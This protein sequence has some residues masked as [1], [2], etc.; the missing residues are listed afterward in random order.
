MTQP[1]R[2]GFTLFA[3]ATALAVLPAGASVP[4]EL[5]PALVSNAPTQPRASIV[6]DIDGDG[7]L[8]IITVDQ[9]GGRVLWF[10]NRLNENLD[11]QAWTVDD[12]IEGPV[13]VAVGDL[14]GDGRLDIAVSAFSLAPG[15]ASV[16]WYRN[17]GNPRTNTPW[18]KQITAT[19]LVFT[20]AVGIAD[21]NNNG[22]NDIIA[23][24]AR[25]SA[26]PFELVWYEN[27][28]FEGNTT[29]LAVNEHIIED[30]IPGV[31]SLAFGDIT[32][33]GRVDVAV[34]AASSIPGNQRRLIAF[35][36]NDGDPT[37]GPWNQVAIDDD[38]Q[39]P[40]R[41]T[42]GDFN[43]NGA[44]DAVAVSQG[45]DRIRPYFNTNGNG[46]LWTQG[47]TLTPDAPVSIRGV[48]LNQNGLLDLVVSTQGAAA[49]DRV[50]WLENDGAGN[51]TEFPVL[52]VATGE[53]L[54]IAT[55]DIR[56]DGDADIVVTSF[57]GG[58]VS[59]VENAA[60]HRNA[61]FNKPAVSV[62]NT[63]G[64]GGDV[65]AA[66]LDRNGL[67]DI[68]TASPNQGSVRWFANTNDGATWTANTITGSLA[69]VT[70]LAVG[71]LAANGRIE[72]VTASPETGRVDVF[73]AQNAAATSWSGVNL[74]MSY[75]RASD[76]AVADVLGNGRLDVIAA[77]PDA[78]L[79]DIVWFENQTGSGVDWAFP[80]V[81]LPNQAGSPA[82]GVERR[83]AVGDITKNGLPDVVSGLT[84]TPGLT[85]RTNNGDGSFS[86]VT[87]DSD[88]AISGAIFA[89]DINGNGA[90]DIV[91]AGAVAGIPELAWFRNENG[92]GSSWQR[93][94][95]TTGDGV[96]NLIAVDSLRL[97]GTV[98][99]L[100]RT[101]APTLYIND[102]A[103]GFS[104][105]IPQPGFDGV[106]R[107]A[108][109]D[110]DRDGDPD[111]AVLR[112][113]TGDATGQH[114]GWFENAG[115]QFSFETEDIAPN[116]LSEGGQAPVLR[117]RP[118][119]EGLVDDAD[120]QITS[121]S[122]R[123]VEPNG[124]PYASADVN[125]MLDSLTVYFDNGN[126]I[127]EPG[128]DTVVETISTFSLTD[129]LMSVDFDDD[130]PIMRLAFGEE[131]DYWIAV[132]AQPDG[133]SALALPRFRI[134]HVT[135]A[136]STAIDGNSDLPLSMAFTP[137]TASSVV[138]VIDPASTPLITLNGPNPLQWE[139]GDSPFVDP[140]AIVDDPNEGA[141]IPISADD[142]G[143]VDVNALGS[144]ILNYSYMGLS[145]AAPD[146]SR[147][148]NVVDTTPP[149]ISL[150]GDAT[151]DVVLGID[152]AVGA[153]YVDPGAT[154]V[155]SFEGDIS[156]AIVV[157]NPVNTAVPGIY[158]VRFNVS[159][160]S[161]NAATEVTRTVRVFDVFAPII[162]L[163]GG[164]SITVEAGVP[165]VDPGFTAIDDVDGD[166]TGQVDVTGTVNT[167]V[168]GFYD[169]TYTVDD[170]SGN[171][172]TVFREVEVVDTTPPVI[173]LIGDANVTVEAGGVYNELG[174]TA[175]DSFE[176]DLSLQITITGFVDTDT[177]G[178]YELRYNVS[179]SSFNAA[180]EVIRTVTVE[181][182]IPPV[183]TL[184]GSANITVERNDSF[185]DPG[186]TASDSF[187]GDL[188]SEIVVT[189]SVNTAVAGVYTLRYNV[190]DSSGN[191]AE[192]V[193]RTVTVI[194]SSLPVITL[195]G[196]ANITTE[197]GEPF[198]DPGATASDLVD[199]DLT[200]DIVVTGS[201]NVDVLG[202]YELRYN[203]SNSGGNAAIEVVRTVTVVDT[204]PPVITL[205]GAATITVELGDSFTDPGATA[206][207]SFEGNITAD[208]VVTGTVDTSTLGE[209]T[210]RYNV[211]DSS[212]NAAI[213]VTRTVTVEQSFDPR[214]IN[215]DMNI[216]AIDVQ[217]VI[218]A[219]LGVDITPLDGDV[220][221][222]GA[223]NAIDVQ[224]VINGALGL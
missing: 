140:G 166:I 144:Y 111:L 81:I 224:L 105:S 35:Y 51:F 2:F 204:T 142:V 146:V 168:L 54:Q 88:F 214:D 76:V 50:F 125:G 62:A 138:Q 170:S 55:G 71:D 152:I 79:G 128:S 48:D 45:Q 150:I 98:D 159:D 149:V 176:G 114:L 124:T 129:G 95:I 107:A 126:G 158:T 189:G 7:D 1:A 190:S 194:D 87:V 132:T 6:A 36:E 46:T 70:R 153:P 178:V 19:G 68:V 82:T 108:V 113:N 145:Q 219:A 39:A 33:N 10:E 101:P 169:L 174:A 193:T 103:G 78:A 67:P 97:N 24:A 216:N 199:G 118:L 21:I 200:N 220:N 151:L 34:T 177:I 143:V 213:E 69:G 184:T 65:L 223:I 57:F 165:F 47:A 74:S 154:A 137:N 191:A 179:D 196:G 23:P 17:D 162:T 86:T 157:T 93:E 206:E 32:G 31:T 117:I 63:V 25:T 139:A 180:I 15:G 215:R 29:I 147:T 14:T 60:I 96:F 104:T 53:Q 99:I 80:Q 89:V 61:I 192:E 209:Y 172:A 135:E 11:W 136:S 210:L 18:D 161:G 44:L 120:I 13:S 175:E 115:G 195:N 27:V 28:L 90:L 212:G 59:L 3:I 102:G 183:I 112:L 131:R 207:D 160:T 116:A 133:S 73:L 221:R 185:T 91:A 155:D 40:T 106:G 110:F 41:V 148:V 208:I 84:G 202:V 122:L 109:A 217:L 182:T 156:G 30:S 201:V 52:S 163:V 222:D 20:Q 38:F 16:A 43:G 171:S 141:P 72:V 211:S 37:A 49:G 66:D 130:D 127:F 94:T 134:V 58:Y 42:L 12:D 205:L 9:I 64:I 56:G 173:T 123:F 187:E 198:A 26:G 121:F 8:D 75:A 100:A 4:F 197:A 5:P 83:I 218:N 186:A 188:T 167:D 22:R 119:H 164:T 92:D 181:D 203:V 77:S 85:L